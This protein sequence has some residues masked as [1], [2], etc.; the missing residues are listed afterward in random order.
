MKTIGKRLP[1]LFAVLALAFGTHAS[2]Q[3]PGR[4]LTELEWASWPDFCK[5]AFIA[6]GWAGQTPFAGRLTRQQVELMRFDHGIPGTHHFCIGMVFVERAKRQGNTPNAQGL[7][8]RAINEIEYSHRQMTPKAPL[9][10][11]VAAYLG[12]A[13]YRLGKRR[14]AL[15]IWQRGIDN[16]PASRESYLAMAEALLAEKKHQQALD[17]LL[18]YDAAKDHP[19]PDAEYFI[20]HTYFLMGRYDDARRHAD[21]AYALGYPFPGLRN[22]LDA[23]GR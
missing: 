2:A 12:T 8:S 11:M 5:S 19:S 15:D 20:A 14:E 22:R 7:L 17:L 4:D 21:Q 10:S 1:P 6:S 3:S 18:R 9:Y 13:H 23:I 16:Q